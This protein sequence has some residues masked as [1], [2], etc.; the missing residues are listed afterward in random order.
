VFVRSSSM[1]DRGASWRSTACL[2]ICHYVVGSLCDDPVCATT[3]T[4]AAVPATVVS[5]PR[6]AGTVSSHRT[7]STFVTPVGPTTRFVW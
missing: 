2:C 7:P 4:P 6:A 3:S 5:A 1:P